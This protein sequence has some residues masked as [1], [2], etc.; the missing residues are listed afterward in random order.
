MTGQTPAPDSPHLRA[1]RDLNDLDLGAL[2]ADA[3]VDLVK[4]PLRQ[5][6]AFLDAV[7]ESGPTWDGDLRTAADGI[8]AKYPQR[9]RLSGWGAEAHFRETMANL[10]HLG[11][12]VRAQLGAM[13][14]ADPIAL[15]VLHASGGH[16]DTAEA[17]R[18]FFATYDQTVEKARAQ[19]LELEAWERIASSWAARPYQEVA[20]GLPDTGGA[21]R[22]RIEA[23]L[24]EHWRVADLE[25][26]LA[27]AKR[28]AADRDAR[29]ADEVLDATATARSERAEAVRARMVAE[30]ALRD[31]QRELGGW[32]K[33]AE[34]AVR[35]ADG[36]TGEGNSPDRLDHA[37]LRERLAGLVRARAAALAGP[38][39]E[40]LQKWR[41]LARDL[42][43]SPATQ[44]DADM[45][46]ALRVY[47]D[48]LI[49]GSA[50][51]SDRLQSTSA[52]LAK[53]RAGTEQEVKD[54]AREAEAL[55]SE[56][57][58]WR[59]S[60]GKV[61][62]ILR[63]PENASIYDHAAAVRL[64]ADA[65][66]AAVPEGS[67]V[68]LA[69]EAAELT[70]LRTAVG[71][72][73]KVNL[74]HLREHVEAGWRQDAKGVEIDRTYGPRTRRT[75]PD[76]ADDLPPPV[77]ERQ[78]DEVRWSIAF[79][80]DP[81][82]VYV[83]SL[84]E[85]EQLRA[86]LAKALDP[87]AEGTIAPVADG[88]TRQP[89]PAVAAPRQISPVG[90]VVLHHGP[91]ELRNG[92]A[93]PRRLSDPEL[94]ALAA[95]GSAA[96]FLDPRHFR[97]AQQP[98]VLAP[99][100]QPGVLGRSL[101]NLAS[102]ERIV[103]MVLERVAADRRE[104]DRLR[105]SNARLAAISGSAP[106]KGKAKRIAELE[107]HLA[108]LQR[109]DRDLGRTTVV[110]VPTP[111]AQRAAVNA[112]SA[113]A[114]Q[115]WAIGGISAASAEP[116]ARQEAIRATFAAIAD[117]ADDADKAAGGVRAPM[118][119]PL[120]RLR[121]AL[122]ELRAKAATAA[123]AEQLAAEVRRLGEINGAHA[124]TASRAASAEASERKW[125]EWGGGVLGGYPH[126]GGD[127]GMRRALG[128]RLAKALADRQASR[129][130][131]EQ[132]LEVSLRHE[133]A[134]QVHARRNAELEDRLRQVKE[135]SSQI[136]DFARHA[137]R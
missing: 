86:D 20:S 65:Q 60:A 115:A 72:P 91:V 31:A 22:S 27:S 10:A 28:V 8:R 130:G 49:Q 59:D 29:R 58:R 64:A 116:V 17:A 1:L 82:L 70:A 90:Y 25:R 125:R 21:K 88:R 12:A 127:E 6:S 2:A 54:L 39:A 93:V 85:A 47:V 4:A 69:E 42:L 95:D 9:G 38:G 46:I 35:S 43:G 137:A 105:A 111:A 26:Q 135:L 100:R 55:R 106:G 78:G 98:D 87:A 14:P 89:I 3:G 113:C 11:A 134:A 23:K 114:S 112:L 117:L 109:I 40:S 92:Y 94:E 13:A 24:R 45:R 71:L 61:R 18:D 76:G 101:A 97:A 120:A 73:G 124:S 96:R 121:N 77:V 67:V 102:P 123:T 5:I 57:A 83:F 7:R 119:S 81:P 104:I 33:I 63:T 16:V 68:I 19:R 126:A 56:L 15:A 103:A 99:L 75:I 44:S 131:A 48:G 118:S 74:R 41:T 108:K 110:H 80:A 51:A 50:E 84:A 30:E 122:A 107:A 36:F 32:R 136:L 62:R 34:D 52:E 133:H 132:A 66:A 37:T 79:P 53:V 128:E 129:R